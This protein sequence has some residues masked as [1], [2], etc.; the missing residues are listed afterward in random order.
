MI[1]RHKT[2]GPEDPPPAGNQPAALLPVN[3]LW[4]KNT[5]RKTPLN[6]ESKQ[7]VNI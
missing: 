3:H 7:F 5:H 2:Q 1:H 6:K 4:T